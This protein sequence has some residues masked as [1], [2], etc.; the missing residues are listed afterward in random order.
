MKSGQLDL[1]SVRR[2]AGQHGLART[3]WRGTSS[4]SSAGRTRS[5]QYKKHLGCPYLTDAVAT[6]Q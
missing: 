3:L 6:Q 1:E 5:H 2:M 4:V